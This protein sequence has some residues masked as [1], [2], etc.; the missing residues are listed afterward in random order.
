MAGTHLRAGSA[1]HAPP[2]S[3]LIIRGG[4]L[5]TERIGGSAMSVLHTR[6]ARPD[7]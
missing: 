2:P 5:V 7:P 1:E 3:S 6:G 4:P